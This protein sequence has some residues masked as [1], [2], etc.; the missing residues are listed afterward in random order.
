[1][2]PSRTMELHESKKDDRP[3]SRPQKRAPKRGKLVD[4]WYRDQSTI[5]CSIV[6][7]I[8]PKNFMLIVFS[9]YNTINFVLTYYLWKQ[10]EEAEKK[11]IKTK[12]PS[13]ND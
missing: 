3:L 12:D 2:I 4:I 10:D 7:F 1:M 6:Y 5:I 13:P 8:V 9:V 11:K